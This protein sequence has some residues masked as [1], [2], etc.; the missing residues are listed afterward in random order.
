MILLNHYRVKVVDG[1]PIISKLNPLVSDAAAEDLKNFHGIDV[2][3]DNTNELEKLE[4][5]FDEMKKEF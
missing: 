4:K 1:E 3:A 2:Y 5:S